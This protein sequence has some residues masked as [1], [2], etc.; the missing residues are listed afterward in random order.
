MARAVVVERDGVQARFSFS[1]VNRNKLYGERRRVVVDEAGRATTGGWLTT[2]GTMLLLPGGRAELYLDEAGDVIDRSEL[3]ATDA[4][5]VV[6]TRLDPTLDVPQALRGPVPPERVLEFV[7]T[8]VYALD[9]EGDLDPDLRDS[10]SRGDIWETDYNY[11][12]AFERQTLF[13]LQSPEGIFGLVGEPAALEP[14]PRAAPPPGDEDPLSDD[15]LDF[16]F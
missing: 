4:N 9:V 2:D 11:V 16:T 15:E 12:A 1:L 6:L 14:L 8:S 10:L 13:I 3:E 7:T 5:G